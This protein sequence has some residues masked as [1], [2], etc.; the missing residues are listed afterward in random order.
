MKHEAALRA[1]VPAGEAEPAPRAPAAWLENAH[2]AVSALLGW[3][4][5]FAVCVNFANVFA[6]Y[7]LDRAMLGAEEL[8]VFAMVWMTFVGAA[9]V[10]L[11]GEHLQMDILAQRLPPRLRIVLG[12]AQTLLLAAL[13]LF[14]LYQSGQ[15]TLQMMEL[16]RD[17]DAMRVPMA[18]PHSGLVVGF[19]LLSG[20]AV[21][22]L[23]GV[24]SMGA[25]P[26]EQN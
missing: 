16:G 22:R 4:L 19:A 1:H 12:H 10:A 13:S 14:M 2:D 20:V 23:L 6:R 26:L 24:R 11:R 7:F 25:A 21:L 8:Q 5:L 18:I 9:V 17:S 3:L 15:F